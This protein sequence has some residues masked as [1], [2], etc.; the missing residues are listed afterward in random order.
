MKT[1][2][3]A[4]ILKTPHHG[5]HEF[6]IDLLDSVNPQISVISSG[7]EPDHGHP[8][9][10]FIAAIGNVSRT[11]KKDE[12][13]VFSTEISSS[14]VEVGRTLEEEIDLSADELKLLDDSTLKKASGLYKRR[15][16][17]MINV[18]TDGNN[19][20]AAR[21]ISSGYLWESYGPITPSPRS[22]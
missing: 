17:G 11:R 13:L 2:I 4:H 20:Y 19:I 3:D 16:H 6:E 15:L 14:F 10:N 18:R 5:S 1:R 22:I 21:R 7:N 12:S 8:R 9:A